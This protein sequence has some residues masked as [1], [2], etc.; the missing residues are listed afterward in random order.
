MCDASHRCFALVTLNGSST[1]VVR[2]VTD[3]NHPKTV[4]TLQQDWPQFVD[5]ATV[6]YVDGPSLF[7]APISGVGTAVVA[8]TGAQ[9]TGVYAWSP[10]G[11]T[12]AYV[13]P[14][15]TST[16]LHLV[17]ANHDQVV[18]RALPAVPVVGCETEPCP[19]ADSWDFRLFYSP[20]GAYVSMVLS[21]ANVN[22]FRR[23]SADGKLLVSS[24]SQSRSMSTWSGSGFYFRDAQGVEVEANGATASF[25]PGVAWIHPTAS[26]DGRHIVYETRDTAGWHHVYVVDTTTH[27]VRELKEARV[28]PTFLTSRYVWYRGETSPG[29]SSTAAYVFDLQTGAE[30]Q[31]VIGDVYDTWPHAA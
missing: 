16:S 15:S 3:I 25:L 8:N 19:G 5:G 13:E 30:Y 31:S 22:A 21:L 14:G 20:D 23:W 7:T 24:N 10:D 2:D 26:P 4:T 9:F 27:S 28:R 29:V 6:S 18:D 17:T 12:V 1:I 11:K